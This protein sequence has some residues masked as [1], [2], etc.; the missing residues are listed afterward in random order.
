MVVAPTLVWQIDYFIVADS[1]FVFVSILQES[2]YVEQFGRLP[3]FE[4]VF[5]LPSAQ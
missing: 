5:L 4:I 2:C 3:G 1:R